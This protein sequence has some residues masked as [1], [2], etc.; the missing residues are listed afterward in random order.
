MAVEA[1]KAPSEMFFSVFGAKLSETVY[2]TGTDLPPKER[3]C[4]R[5]E[6]LEKEMSK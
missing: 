2:L 1:M 4:N 6:L 5:M 3:R